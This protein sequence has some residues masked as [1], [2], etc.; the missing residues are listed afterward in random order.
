SPDPKYNGYSVGHWEDDYTLV[1]DTTGIDERTWLSGGGD[2]HTMNSHVPESYKRT[3]HN[4]L[5]LNVT[6]YD[7]ALYTKPFHPGQKNFGWVPSQ[8]LDE[9]LC[10]PSDVIEYLKAVGDPAGSDPNASTGR[11]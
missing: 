4:D 2:P 6:V 1:I 11:F 7:P 8:M 3:S 10:V 5:E 9:K